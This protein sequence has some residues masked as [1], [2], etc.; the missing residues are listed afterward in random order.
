MISGG[1]S[2]A[3]YA[4]DPAHAEK[5]EG[6]KAGGKPKATKGTKKTKKKDEVVKDPE[7]VGAESPIDDKVFDAELAKPTAIDAVV[8]I[9]ASRSMLRTDPQRLRNQGAKLFMRFLSEG[10]RLG[11]IQFDR[12]AQAVVVT[13]NT[14]H[15]MP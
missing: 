2:T 11:I 13:A 15:A 7:P 5:K 4:S 9:D 3:A 1:N 10:D 14:I 12:E 6:A 8:I